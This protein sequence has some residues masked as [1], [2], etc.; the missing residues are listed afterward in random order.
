MHQRRTNGERLIKAGDDKEGTPESIKFCQVIIYNRSIRALLCGNR[1][2]LRLYRTFVQGLKVL[3]SEVGHA[4]QPTHSSL[5]IAK[6]IE[7]LG[8]SHPVG[9]N[10]ASFRESPLKLRSLTHSKDP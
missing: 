7:D 4:D 9:K 10:L 5:T 1:S 6:S 2:Y 3:G 8:A